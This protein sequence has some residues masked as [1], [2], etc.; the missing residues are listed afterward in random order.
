MY[1]PQEPD[2]SQPKAEPYPPPEAYLPQGA[3]PYPPPQPG[4]PYPYSSQGA[5]PYPPQ[6]GMAPYPYP[7][8]GAYPYPPQ[9]PYI[10]QAQKIQNRRATNAMIYGF[11]SIALSLI[12]LLQEVGAAGLITGTFA[13]FYGFTALKIAK[14]LPGNP[15]RA[16]AITG[17]VLGCVAWLLIIISLIIRFTPT[18]S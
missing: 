2:P 14:R 10:P 6:P 1:S 4:A 9:G 16:Q 5:Y 8:Q 13:I 17:I 18:G 11:I 15:G 3:Y 12:T 7:P